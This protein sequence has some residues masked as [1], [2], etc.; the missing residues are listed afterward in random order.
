MDPLPANPVNRPHVIT[1][2]NNS[3][4]ATFHKVITFYNNFFVQ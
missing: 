2:N 4:K 3:A 1:S